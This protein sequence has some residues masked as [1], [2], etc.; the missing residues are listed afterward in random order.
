MQETQRGASMCENSVHSTAQHSTAQH[1]AARRTSTPLMTSSV[2][3]C[4]TQRS[5]MARLPLST[6]WCSTSASG[7]EGPVTSVP[8]ADGAAAA[9]AWPPSGMPAGITSVWRCVADSAAQQAGRVLWEAQPPELWHVGMQQAAPRHRWQW[10]WAACTL[11]APRG[12]LALPFPMSQKS[13]GIRAQGPYL[14]AGL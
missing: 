4:T 13:T 9:G 14:P 6:L 2:R 10:C 11:G 7:A 1:S 5:A 8:S 12:R 3:L